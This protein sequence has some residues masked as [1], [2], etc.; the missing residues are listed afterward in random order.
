MITISDIEYIKEELKDIFPDAV[1]GSIS[2]SYWG[3]GK[4]TLHLAYFVMCD[5]VG[6]YKIVPKGGLYQFVSWDTST[7]VE[8]MY[9]HHDLHEFI[10]W[11]REEFTGVTYTID[12]TVNFGDFV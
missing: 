5:T 2:K 12:R 11:V 7:G 3:N 9:S 4:R 8:W 6:G 10:R 1:R